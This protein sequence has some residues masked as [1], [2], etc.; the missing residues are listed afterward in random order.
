MKCED[1]KCGVNTDPERKACC[2]SKVIVTF[3]WP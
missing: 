1:D 2:V 3:K